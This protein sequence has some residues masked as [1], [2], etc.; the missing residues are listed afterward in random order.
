MVD[1]YIFL[2]YASQYKHPCT[3]AFTLNNDT[4]NYKQI[5]LVSLLKS[6]IVIKMAKNVRKNDCRGHA[7]GIA[8]GIPLFALVLLAGTASA[9]NVA[10]ASTY[11]ASK[12]YV[13]DLDTKSVVKTID[14]YTLLPSNNYCSEDPAGF[15]DLKV[16]DGKIFLSVTGTE[17]YSCQISQVK[18][19][20]L[21]LG[22]IK[23]INVTLV[24]PPIKG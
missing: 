20:N 11:D 7:L 5:F 19:I 13:V 4:Y 18:V 8:F 10:Y 14:I 22:Y 21:D 9:A 12:L 23:T 6:G 15:N 2:G 24:D 3:S 17:E 16:V 1:G